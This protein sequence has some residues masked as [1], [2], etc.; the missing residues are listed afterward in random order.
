MTPVHA[1]SGVN[2]FVIIGGQ[3]HSYVDILLDTTELC[4]DNGK[5][6]TS[7]MNVLQ[8]LYIANER[9][10]SLGKHTLNASKD[11]YF[12]PSNVAFAATV[13][14]VRTPTGTRLV[15]VRRPNGLL[16]VLRYYVAIGSYDRTDFVN[17]HHQPRKWDEVKLRL[18]ERGKIWDITDQHQLCLTGRAPARDGGT[19][20]RYSTLKPRW[21]LVRCRTCVAV[22]LWS[23]CSFAGTPPNVQSAACKPPRTG[24]PMPSSWS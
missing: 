2:R 15:I 9:Q 11:F 12:P 14:E 17:E 18:G 10:W 22:E 23:V 7:T 21:P 5:G 4:G 13:F 16:S 6:K 19:N 3:I 24:F 1:L 20:A 8:F